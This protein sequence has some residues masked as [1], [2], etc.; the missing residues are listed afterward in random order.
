VIRGK[1]DALVTGLD[2]LKTLLVIEAIQKA[3]ETRTLVEVECSLKI[4]T[5]GVAA[6]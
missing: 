5:N 1:A 2:G 3:A 4:S 6:Q